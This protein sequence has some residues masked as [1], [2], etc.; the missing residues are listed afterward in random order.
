MTPICYKF[1][2]VKFLHFF[3]DSTRLSIFTSVT[4]KC[5]FFTPVNVNFLIF[6]ATLTLFS[7][8]PNTPLPASVPGSACG[9]KNFSPRR[10]FLTPPTLPGGLQPSGSIWRCRLPTALLHEFT[11]RLLPNN[12]YSGQPLSYI[13]SLKDGTSGSISPFPLLKKN[14]AVPFSLHFLFVNATGYDSILLP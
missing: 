11:L 13:L 8:R 3:S 1:T 14:W 6:D 7:P 5:P 12:G 2:P 4:P 10:K 9:V